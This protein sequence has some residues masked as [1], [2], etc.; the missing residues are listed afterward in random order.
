[1]NP[2]NDSEAK[3]EAQGAVDLPTPP[4]R[5]DP[6][7]NGDGGNSA[8]AGAGSPEEPLTYRC[9]RETVAASPWAARRAKDAKNFAA[10][11]ERFL[12]TL[13][14]HWDDPVGEE[15]Y[16]MTVFRA[17]L[18]AHT[19]RLG[20][21]RGS[22]AWRA[23]R[24]HITRPWKEAKKHVARFRAAAK[25]R[26]FAEALRKALDNCGK[27]ITQFCGETGVKY[28]TIMPWLSGRTHPE[29][30]S[31]AIVEKIEDALGLPRGEL[32]QHICLWPNDRHYVKCRTRVGRR[33]ARLAGKSARYRLTDWDKYTK[34]GH[35]ESEGDLLRRWKD[36]DPLLG[37][38]RATPT[39]GW[40][41]RGGQGGAEDI[42]MADIAGYAGFL[43]N[44][45]GKKPEDFSMA[46]LAD[47]VGLKDYFDFRASRSDSRLDD[48]E[49][50]GR[51]QG[52]GKRT[53]NGSVLRMLGFVKSLVRPRTGLLWQKGE[54]FR[55]LY[56]GELL[57]DPD[58]PPNPLE[59][60]WQCHCRLL[61]ERLIA[62]ET[63][64]LR[65][66]QLVSTR[67]TETINKILGQDD[68]WAV[69]FL[70]LARILMY[71]FRR[72]GADGGWP[73]PTSIASPWRWRFFSDS[74]LVPW[75][76]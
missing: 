50:C 32:T 36:P 43:V 72:A 35:D 11:G 30:A 75:W 31:I 67:D 51:E 9:L 54:R 69:L 52:T 25:G 12:E 10:A 61:H 21:V 47:P 66:G 29:R 26:E 27:S 4:Q 28:G 58:S 70:W 49:I 39:S 44:V 71:T 1:M 40:R 34:R 23:E 42:A 57:T 15:S 46:N 65:H 18:D 24:H 68:P 37:D 64:W 16:D 6:P 3:D 59:T 22:S 20:L 8:G 53:Y 74:A 14:R 33:Q 63:H 5:P 7:V 45:R 41:R 60:D 48:P 55:P 56:T 38:L 17:L 13:G 19:A 73:G 2:T 62:A 76:T